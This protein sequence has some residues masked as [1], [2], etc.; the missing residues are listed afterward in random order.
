VDVGEAL[1]VAVFVGVNVIEGVNVEVA[2]PGVRVAVGVC[3]NVAVAVRV[4]V[5]VA[6]RVN[7]LVAVRVNVL[8][9]VRV[10]VAEASGVNVFVGPTDV[11]VFVGVAVDP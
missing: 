7:V 9:A 11:A 3:V 5:L 2:E 8:V 4:N 6:V 10:F 1:A